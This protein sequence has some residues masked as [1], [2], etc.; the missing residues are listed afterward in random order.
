[1]DRG[2]SSNNDGDDAFSSYAGRWIAYSGNRVIAQG[3]TP[4]QAVARR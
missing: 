1:M 3:G 2:K 4:E